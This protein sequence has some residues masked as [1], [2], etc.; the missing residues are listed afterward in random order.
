METMK[1]TNMDGNSLIYATIVYNTLIV[2][3]RR[4]P[5]FSLSHR[6]RSNLSGYYCTYEGVTVN[7]IQ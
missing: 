7:K 5:G 2:Q 6:H 3:I 4:A 1:Y